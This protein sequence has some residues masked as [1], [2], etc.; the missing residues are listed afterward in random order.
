MYP[1]KFKN[2][3][4]T[5]V[6]GGRDFEL[7]RDNLPD[8][9]IGESWDIAC[10]PNGMSVVS[11]GEFKDTRLDHL[12]K[13]KGEQI[14][15]SKISK[16]KFPIL[17]KLLNTRGK[18]S[19]QVHADDEYAKKE[20]EM[21]KNEVWYV[22]D[23]FENASI[24]VGLKENCTKEQ[25]VAKRGNLEEYMNRVKIKKGE[26]YFIPS[27]LIHAICEGAIIAEIQQNSDTTYRFYDYNRGRELHIEK[28]LEVINL[29]L[30]CGKSAG[31]RIE[32]DGF[33]KTYLC[34]VKD[35]SLELYEVN[36]KITEKSD[37]ERFYTFTCVEG[38]GKIVYGSNFESIKKGESILIPACL[39]QYTLKGKMKL[40]KAYV[41][42]IEKVE[43]EILKEVKK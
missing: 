15:G 35:F 38:Q 43:Q 23:A 14:I 19:V 6:W 4:H 16:E 13:N 17:I 30:K 3:Y 9:N 25:M 18:L 8:G 11:N 5:K 28:A 1:L 36:G 7:F 10:H 40:L 42:D 22:I 21:G 26:T 32:K 33:I 12:I 2:I 24:V 34:L 20:N 29:G 39:G 31:L 37:V 27:G 41:P